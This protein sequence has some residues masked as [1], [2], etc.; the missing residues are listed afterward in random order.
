MT[1]APDRSP[2][3]VIAED[4]ALVAMMVAEVLA[5][6]G[7]RTVWRPGGPGAGAADR[8]AGAAPDAAVVDLRLAHGLDGR[9]VVRRLRERC[10]GMPVV[11]VTDLDRSAPEADLR[12]LGGPTARLRKPFTGDQVLGRLEGLLGTP[13]TA[14]RPS[15]RATDA[16]AGAA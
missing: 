8:V 10:S 2:T 9:D 12:G 14:T 4:E 11:V 1:D 13:S 3:V 7:Y 5:E 16:L 6:A 15:R